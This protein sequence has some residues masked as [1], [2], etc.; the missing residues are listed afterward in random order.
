MK[1]KLIITFSVILLV[2]VIG[3][4]AYCIYSNNTDKAVNVK[5]EEFTGGSF[6]LVFE[7]NGG[8]ELNMLGV[9]IACSPDSYPELPIP[10][11]KGYKFEGWYYDEELTNKVSAITTNEIT[12]VEKLDKNGCRTGY[13]QIKLYAKWLKK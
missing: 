7:T 4:G 12:P 2:G 13:E 6:D 8:N 9:C 1:K 10:T 3:G 11:K 5:C